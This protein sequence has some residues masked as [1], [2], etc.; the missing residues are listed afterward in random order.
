MSTTVLELKKKRILDDGESSQTAQIHV[1]C[2][3]N[4]AKKRICG[5][6]SILASGYKTIVT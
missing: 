1:K 6:K 2:L 3:D 5:E 4:S